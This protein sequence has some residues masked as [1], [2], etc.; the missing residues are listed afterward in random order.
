MNEVA[1]LVQ[2]QSGTIVME[3][4]LTIFRSRIQF[5][6]MDLL[7]PVIRNGNQPAGM[8]MGDSVL[9]LSGLIDGAVGIVKI[10]PYGCS[11]EQRTD[12]GWHGGQALSDVIAEIGKDL[13]AVHEDVGLTLGDNAA[14]QFDGNISQGCVVDSLLMRR[15]LNEG[16]WG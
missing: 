14:A 11:E 6:R 1:V 5:N 15:V 9:H 4:V 16:R 13:T 10:D 3:T 7:G 2:E 12:G 8:V